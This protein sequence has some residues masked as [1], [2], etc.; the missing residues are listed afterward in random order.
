MTDK[1][2]QK[3]LPSLC[4]ALKTRHS[5]QLTIL[6]L[7]GTLLLNWWWARIRIVEPVSRLVPKL[8]PLLRN[9]TLNLNIPIL[10][11]MLPISM[12][13]SLKLISIQPQWQSTSL[14]RSNVWKVVPHSQSLSILVNTHHLK[15]LPSNSPPR[16]LP[17]RSLPPLAHW[18][19]C[20]ATMLVKLPSHVLLSLLPK[21]TTLLWRETVR[22]VIHLVP[23]L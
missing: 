9:I 17:Q 20:W 2:P 22:L 18:N 15:S 13:L 19:W 4:L 11:T 16:T 5:S 6:T 8:E 12:F 10:V 21:Y 3:T 7:K 1:L 23:I 14:P